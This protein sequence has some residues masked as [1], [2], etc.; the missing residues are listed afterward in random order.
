MRFRGPGLE[1]FNLAQCW[2]FLLR[3][4]GSGLPALAARGLKDPTLY[5]KPQ[6]L[7]S[8]PQTPSRQRRKGFPKG[9]RV[10]RIRSLA[11]PFGDPSWFRAWE[12]AEFRV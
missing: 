6:T 2:E 4:Q 12:D 9:A 11:T 10:V 3:I 1:L 7:N 8:K 5:P